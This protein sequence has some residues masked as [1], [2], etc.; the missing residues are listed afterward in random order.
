MR[1]LGLAILILP[2]VWAMPA[3]GDPA[4]RSPKAGDGVLTRPP[5]GSLAAQLMLKLR[6]QM[7]GGGS[8]AAA[9][10][11]NHQEW[12]TLTPDQREQFRD[13]VRAYHRKDPKAQQE[14]LERYGTFLSLEKEKREAY[15]LRARW[16]K[17]VVA[18]FTPEQRDKLR[19]M[20][21]MARAKALIARRDELVR[22]GKLKLND[23]PASAP[24]RSRDRPS[25]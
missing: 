14:F 23:S 6:L 19:K 17:A 7:A 16:V 10:D 24:A 15:R 2:L 21:S 4:E 9:L 8:L 20:S 25:K 3:G 1:K 22:Q 13:A 11:H 12:K 5:R 18:T